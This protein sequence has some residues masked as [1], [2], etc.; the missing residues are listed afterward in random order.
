MIIFNL[1]CDFEHHFEG[2]FKNKDEFERQIKEH[3]VSC[4]TCG[5]EQIIKTPT[6][7]RINRISKKSSTSPSAT[8]SQQE[9]KMISEQFIDDLSNH[10]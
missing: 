5:S 3:M 8:V 9:I 1:K 7:S 4:P 2:W 6:A 10:G